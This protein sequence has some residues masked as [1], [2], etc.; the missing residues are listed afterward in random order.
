MREKTEIETLM[1]ESFPMAWAC[2]WGQD[3]M[4]QGGVGLWNALVYK[5]VRQMF[6]W[7]QPGS[8]SMGSPEGEAE[9]NVDETQHEVLLTEG[10]WLADTACTQ[11]LW[12]AVMGENPSAF[13]GLDRPVDTVSWDDTQGFLSRLNEVVEGQDVR[14]PSEAEWEYAC[15][16][17]TTSVFSFGENITP[18]QV[19]YDARFPYAKGEKGQYREKTVVVK[20]LPANPW[21]LYE[22]HANVREWCE[23]WY[24]GEYQRDSKVNPVGPGSG[25]RRVVRGGSWVSNGGFARSANRSRGEPD[26]R[27]NS[28]GF[29]LALGHPLVGGA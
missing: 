29:R 6:R 8:F 1:P 9:R 15:R 17:G 18:E 12:A 4:V 26:L 2:E 28:L 16:A 10:F 21:G 11:A 20:T 14:L 13:K 5:D 27:L 25:R 23:D 7:I 24:Q 19:N 3:E 22:M